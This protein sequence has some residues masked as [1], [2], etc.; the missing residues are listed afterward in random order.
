M[1]VPVIIIGRGKF[2]CGL[3]IKNGEQASANNLVRAREK[4]ITCVR[5]RPF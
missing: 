3:V 4:T 1:R 2:D 5:R